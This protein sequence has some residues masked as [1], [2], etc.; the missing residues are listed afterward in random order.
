MLKQSKEN[1]LKKFESSDIG[2]RVAKLSATASPAIAAMIMFPSE[3]YTFLKTARE[4][5]FEIPMIIFFGVC[6][7]WFRKDSARIVDTRIAP[8]TEALV[9]GAR[10]SAEVSL[11]VKSLSEE[12]K[13]NTKESKERARIADER[14]NEFN[15]K[16]LKSDER[17]IEV[18][19]EIKDVSQKVLTIETRIQGVLPVMDQNELQE[20]AHKVAIQSSGPDLTGYP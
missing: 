7:W 3:T 17:F 19:K 1:V 15:Q 10:V 2:K 9:E 6:I 4:L 5:G 20:L 16:F 11:A 13:E 12:V 14:Y 8:V 18:S